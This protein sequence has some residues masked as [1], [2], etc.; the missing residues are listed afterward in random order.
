MQ[1]AEARDPTCRRRRRRH[2]GVG[3]D[4]SV[5]ERD[6]TNGGAR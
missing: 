3:V 6:I 5:M 4:E 2:V 1:H